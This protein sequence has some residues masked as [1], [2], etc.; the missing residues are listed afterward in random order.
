MVYLHIGVR[1]R[2]RPELPSLGLTASKD[3]SR[4]CASTSIAMPLINKFQIALVNH[5]DKGK[6]RKDSFERAL[7]F[8]AVK[9]DQ[10]ER[11]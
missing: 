8:C 10:V 5:K 6:W 7:S 4:L 3:A 1:R 9:G 11:L 2:R